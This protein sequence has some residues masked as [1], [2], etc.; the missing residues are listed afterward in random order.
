MNKKLQIGIIGSAGTEE[1]PKAGQPKQEIFNIAYQ[2]G[3]SIAKNGAILI[4]GGKGGIMEYAAKGAKDVGGI[5]VGVVKGEKRF[6]S[7]Q[8]TDIEVVSGMVGSGGESIMVLMCDGIVGV[9]GGS[10]TLQELTIA[11]YNKI[12]TV[13]I[14]TQKGWSKTLAGKYLDTRKKIKFQSAKTPEKAV[15]ILFNLIRP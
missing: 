1:Y 12:P 5:T 2:L 11:Y 10:G 8:Y 7:N 4:T 13:L 14:N 9:G 6:T 3:K 15:K